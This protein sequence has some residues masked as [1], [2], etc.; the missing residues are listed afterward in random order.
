[1]TSS[2]T[3]YLNADMQSLSSSGELPKFLTIPKASDLADKALEFEIGCTRSSNH[4]TAGNNTYLNMYV[5]GAKAIAFMLEANTSNTV[6]YNPCRMFSQM[7]SFYHSEG[8]IKLYPSAASNAVTA[9]YFVQPARTEDFITIAPG[10]EVSFSLSASF[11]ADFIMFQLVK[12]DLLDEGS[13]LFKLAE[14]VEVVG[15]NN[16]AQVFFNTSLGDTPADYAGKWLDVTCNIEVEPVTDSTPQVL[17]INLRQGSI[18]KYLCG[19]QVYGSSSVVR[20]WSRRWVLPINSTGTIIPAEFGTVTSN[21]PS[22]ANIISAKAYTIGTQT[23]DVHMYI[24]SV[25]PITFKITDY[26]VRLRG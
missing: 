9:S 7:L 20:S 6:G 16:F 11:D 23:G 4:S 25:L 15:N 18:N 21:L 10:A 8:G 14:P 22:F 13:V 2:K 19:Q 17:N 5:D 3:I 1:M 24:T 12:V 26:V